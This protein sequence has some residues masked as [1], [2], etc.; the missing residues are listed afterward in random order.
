MHACIAGLQADCEPRPVVPCDV[1]LHRAAPCLGVAPVGS[2][3][4]LRFEPRLFRLP[5]R[6]FWE[7][8]HV[9]WMQAYLVGDPVQ[10]PATVIS[11]RA[12]EA[13]YNV[14]LFKRLQSA[15]FPVNVLDTQVRVA[16]AP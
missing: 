13:G 12:A 3:E 8:K 16:R 5:Q 7:V 9:L 2:V 14:S 6:G 11:S 4:L 15:D 10:L 1:L